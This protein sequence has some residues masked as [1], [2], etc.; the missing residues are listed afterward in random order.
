MGAV[1]DVLLKTELPLP[2]FIKGKVRDTYNLG[3]HLL[4]VTTDRVSA[5]DVILPCG[6]PDKGKILNLMS[7]FWMNKT[8][9]IIPNHLVAVVDDVSILDNF[10]PAAK[11]FEYPRYLSGRSV[12][13]KKAGR[14][15]VECVIRGYLAG[16]GWSEYQQK[17]SVCGINLAPGLIESQ[18]LPEPIL[19]PTTKADEG[20]DMPM[21]FETLE[22]TVGKETASDLT[23]KSI[24]LYNFASRY[25]SNRGFI[26]ADTKFEF[27]INANQMIIIDEMLTP[28]SSRFWD[29]NT[30]EPGRPQDSFDKQ[31]I[32]DW[33]TKSGWDKNPPGPALPDEVIHL[34]SNRYRQAYETITGDALE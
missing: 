21:D 33:L 16:S 30:Y 23:Q 25:F 32:R 18:Q 24:E 6:I 11:R 5:F 34:A 14:I 2:A 19:T 28:D 13:V 7:A 27:G 12:I 3:E 4:I 29:K 1:K 22:S 26:I 9:H 10:L 8:K 15:A 20:H 17:G 31:P